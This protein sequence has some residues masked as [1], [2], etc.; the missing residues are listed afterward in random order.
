[1]FI[2][3]EVNAFQELIARN[4][5]VPA[6]RTEQSSVVADP[7]PQRA[8]LRRRDSSADALDQ[9]VFENSQGRVR[10]LRINC[11]GGLME[12]I[13]I[14]IP[15]ELTAMISGRYAGTVPKGTPVQL[16]KIPTLAQVNRE[17]SVD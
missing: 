3:E 4:N 14:D 10:Y 2:D 15:A 7:K 9:F 5:P 11:P 8:A 16:D 17:C 6:S 1:M 12:A 13:V